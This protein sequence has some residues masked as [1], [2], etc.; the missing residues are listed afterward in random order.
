MLFLNLISP[1]HKKEVT[2]RRL[3]EKIRILGI[4]L[5]V[6]FIFLS[7]IFLF[8]QFILDEF[9]SEAISKGSSI[10]AT[11]GNDEFKKTINKRIETITDIQQNY[12]PWTYFIEYIAQSTNDDIKFNS[13]EINNQEEIIHLR[14]VAGRR[15]SLLDFKNNLKNF[16]NKFQVI[17]PIE[18]ILKKENVNFNIKIKYNLENF[19]Y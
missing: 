2:W 1:E 7:A 15:T 16:E 3:Y 14:G 9:Y 4:S 13:I 5:I 6:F 19:K 11:K 17:F 12:V 8:A 10:S 18:N